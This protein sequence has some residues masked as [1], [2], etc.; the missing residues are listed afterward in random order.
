MPCFEIRVPRNLGLVFQDS[1]DQVFM[2]TVDELPVSMDQA[3][4][5]PTKV[6]DREGKYVHAHLEGH[7]HGDGGPEHSYP[8][9]TADFPK[10]RRVDA[11]MSQTHVIRRSAPA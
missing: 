5:E 7:V 8:H 1:G 4:A 2:P 9:R 11:G 10:G 6:I 3:V